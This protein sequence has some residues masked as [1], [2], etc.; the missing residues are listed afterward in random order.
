MEHQRGA[1]TVQTRFD[2]A[3][4]HA[5]IVRDV[6]ERTAVHLCQDED[7][8]LRFGQGSNC[9]FEGSPQLCLLD[10]HFGTWL[11]IARIDGFVD[12]REGEV[13][14]LLAI[15]Q[16]TMRHA[17]HPGGELRRA[18]ELES[19]QHHQQLLEQLLRGIFEF[20]APEARATHHRMQHGR[21]TRQERSLGTTFA[22]L[23]E[24]DGGRV[25]LHGRR[26]TRAETSKV[27]TQR[28]TLKSFNKQPGSPYQ[29]DEP[30]EQGEQ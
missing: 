12:R 17:E 30:T 13:P 8:T 6:L 27:P 4:W 9:H 14:A 3:E 22:T 24:A 21:I 19:R 25:Q 23:G 11:R 10:P 7:A 15:E 16:P 1:C 2:G 18:D 29:Q 5:L 26:V 20:G 28:K